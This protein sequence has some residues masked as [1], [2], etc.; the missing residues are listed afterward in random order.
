[1]TK[2]DNEK[3]KYLKTVKNLKE[4][5]GMPKNGI[6]RDSAIKR[7][8]LCFDVAWK[9]IKIILEEK[10]G[11]VCNSPNDCFKQAYGWKW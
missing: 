10:K 2:S 8:E 7:F 6:N 5:L 9:F 1:M 11:I 3:E 4:V